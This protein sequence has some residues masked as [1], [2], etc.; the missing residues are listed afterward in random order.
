MNFDDCIFYNK[1]IQFDPKSNIRFYHEVFFRG[2]EIKVPEA[3]PAGLQIQ[4]L[5]NISGAELKIEESR[6]T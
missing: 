3:W 5:S 4:I 1:Y 6:K 2:K